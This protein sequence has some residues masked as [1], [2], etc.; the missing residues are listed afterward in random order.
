[1]KLK[2][3]TAMAL[4]ILVVA[5][6]SAGPLANAF[7]RQQVSIGNGLISGRLTVNEALRL[8][9]REASIRNQY[10]FLKSTGGGLGPV[11]RA[12]LGARL[13]GAR[14]AIFYHKHN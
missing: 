12:Y 10:L 2:L 14:A 11:E 5:P 9:S 8:E 1:M 13:V 4:A 6:A 7:H 3:I